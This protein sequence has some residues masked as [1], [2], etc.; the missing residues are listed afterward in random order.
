MLY[1]RSVSR[2][3][4]YF[5]LA[6]F[7]LFCGGAKADD[8]AFQYYES[9]NQYFLKSEHNAAYVE[10]KNSLRLKPKYTPA[11]VLL[12]KLYLQNRY[13]QNAIETFR[14]SLHLGADI[15]VVLMPLGEALLGDNQYN[16][17]LA[18]AN[19]TSLSVNAQS[20]RALLRGHTR[21]ALSEPQVALKNYYQA[22]KL[23]PDSTNVINVLSRHLLR[24]EQ[25]ELAEKFIKQAEKLD[26]NKQTTTHTKGLFYLAKKQY[27]RAEAEFK[28]TLNSDKDTWQ[29]K[30]ALAA[31]Y[32]S[33]QRDEEALSIIQEL[34]LQYPNDP[35]T[36]LLK[37]K[38][39][40][41]S[42]ESAVGRQLLAELNDQLSLLKPD[43]L[44]FNP[45]LHYI[46]G[47]ASFLLQNYEAARREL[48][49]YTNKNPRH[50]DAK[51]L[52]AKIH[53]ELGSLTTARLILE[54][55]ITEVEQ[56]LEA[57]ELLCDLQ[58]R[59]ND[60]Y[61]CE[62]LI[63]T[64]ELAFGNPASLTLMRARVR[65]AQ[66]K[67][68]SAIAL[69]ESTPASGDSAV[70]FG[71]F[72]IKLYISNYDLNKAA[73]LAE[74][75][76]LSN[77]DNPILLNSLGAVLMQQQKLE[78]SYKV[79]KYGFDISPTF[80][81]L[82]FNLAQV[83]FLQKKLN[84]S[85][86][87]LDLF[88]KAEPNSIEG[89]LLGAKLSIKEGDAVSAIEQLTKTLQIQP[90][91][92]TAIS[93]YIEV[94][95]WLGR[96]EQALELVEKYLFRDRLN[97]Y[98]IEQKARLLL[99][100]RDFESA[101]KQL[102]VLRALWS[103]QPA[104]LVALSALMKQANDL[105]SVTET[106]ELARKK[107]PNNARMQSIEVKALIADGSFTAAEK[108]IKEMLNS[109]HKGHF[110]RLYGDL[111]T[112][113]NRLSEAN[114]HYLNAFSASADDRIALLKAYHLALL[115]HQQ[116]RFENLL[117][118]LVKAMPNLL[119]Y[120]NLWADYLLQT[121]EYELAIVQY[122]AL[123][124][125]K[126]M[127]NKADLHNNMAYAQMHIDPEQALVNADAAMKLSP[128]KAAVLDTFGR[129]QYLLG[130]YQGSL[131]SLRKA[132][133]IDKRNPH[134]NY[135]LAATLLKLEREN[136]AREI[137][138]MMSNSDISQLESEQQAH[139]DKVL[140]SSL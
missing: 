10:L 66:N 83:S 39:L 121:K 97:A 35:N 133:V 136:E 104:K 50:F 58:I 130:N 80:S 135:H 2:I 125:V 11:V 31:V 52:L 18:L 13:Y 69:L 51:L 25:F 67:I 70:E 15:E 22:Y 42:E 92:K 38:L 30:R 85:R 78:T 46:N 89:R 87:Y 116:A 53:I 109:E 98:L 44:T 43:V 63:D 103:D 68:K 107:L 17:V 56:N 111:L 72:L 5:I 75:L 117:S 137:L 138:V 49:T 54:R 26:S 93:M 4:N 74:E 118:A 33:Q 65:L 45:W 41:K 139:V 6:F 55:D 34:L 88:L 132:N 21:V 7:I 90:D 73:L 59:S 114:E 79:L 37:A 108:I 134:I 112:Q 19:N 9:A 24:L 110:H 84:E 106:L 64:V 96:H 62:Q 115:G 120:Q 71:S 91:D 129:I 47:T 126:E 140:S 122:E 40:L 95:K 29:A 131:S 60:E 16:Q 1:Q 105:K 14:K 8:T 36:K 86:H 3:N 27:G 76:L 113:Q 48:T 32:I 28:S 12:G 123:L 20:D 127:P 119:Y 81:P 124:M 128:N 102:K 99:R 82:L 23:R 77:K 94:Q 101:Q 100:K 57:V 61:E